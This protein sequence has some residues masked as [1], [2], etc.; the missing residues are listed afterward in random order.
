MSS[1]SG[2]NESETLPARIRRWIGSRWR[3]FNAWRRG[4][5]FL[6]GLL[7]CLAGLLITWVPMR[8]LPDIAFIGGEMAG[9][10]A[11]GAL[12]GVF[13][14]LSGL[15]ALSRPARAHGAGVVGIIL[16]IF[17]LFGSLGG[18]LVGMLLGIIGGNLC[19][20]WKPSGDA[21]DEAVSEPSVIDKAAAR[22]NAGFARLV[23]TIVLGCRAG[24]ERITRRGTD[25]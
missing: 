16:S 10:L 14:F 9:F 12:F 11:I 5:P 1:E 15:Y 20:A 23:G 17:S 8:I 22:I 18:L 24:L 13:V 25:E 7:L 19:I 2:Q 4:R 3:R 6:G 21:V